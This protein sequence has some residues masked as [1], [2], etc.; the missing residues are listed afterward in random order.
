MQGETAEM[1]ETTEKYCK[2]QALMQSMKKGVQKETQRFITG[3]VPR[4]SSHT[5]DPLP[6]KLSKV[7]GQQ[8]ER[9]A[10]EV[11]HSR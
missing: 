10:W 8:H 1:T 9:K 7:K 11:H 4:P 2:M 3:L 6:Q 5:V